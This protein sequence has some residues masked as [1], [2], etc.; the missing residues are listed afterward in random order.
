MSTP[1][2]K[3]ASMG[4]ESGAG[5]MNGYGLFVDFYAAPGTVLHGRIADLLLRV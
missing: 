4:R 1:V 5:T 2:F 3:G